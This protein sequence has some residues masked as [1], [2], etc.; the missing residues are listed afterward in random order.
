MNQQEDGETFITRSLIICILSGF[1]L[2]EEV[3]GIIDHL[4]G[5]ICLFL[6]VRLIHVVREKSRE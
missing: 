5:S 3:R 1:V 6:V 2:D 4:L